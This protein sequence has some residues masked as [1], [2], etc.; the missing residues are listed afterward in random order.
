MAVVEGL[1]NWQLN[2]SVEVQSEKEAD[3]IFGA[4]QDLINAMG[5]T[6]WNGKMFRDL[7]IEKALQVFR[8]N[9]EDILASLPKEVVEAYYPERGNHEEM[10]KLYPPEEY[11]W[12]NDSMTYVKIKQR[13]LEVV[14]E[15]EE[16]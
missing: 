4:I 7:K 16:E 1:E 5:H 12:D 3:D 15:L 13:H 8:A 6:Q 10:K 2:F 11:E 9:K 14:P